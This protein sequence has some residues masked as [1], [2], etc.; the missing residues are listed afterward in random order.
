MVSTQRAEFP[1]KQWWVDNPLAIIL[2]GIAATIAVVLLFFWDRSNPWPDEWDP[3]VTDLVAYVEQDRGLTFDHPVNIR[4]VD[5][6]VI[7]EDFSGDEQTLDAYTSGDD[8][9]EELAA[10]YRALGLAE[11][12]FDFGETR[13]SLSSAAVEAYYDPNTYTIVVPVNEPLGPNDPI[14]VNTRVTLVH[15]LVHGLQHQRLPGFGPQTDN[16]EVAL[17]IMEGDA[18]LVESHYFWQLSEVEQEAYRQQILDTADEYD[19]GIATIPPVFV[20]EFADSYILGEVFV[21][22]LHDEGGFARINLSYSVPPDSM[23]AF[24]DPYS[25]L[26]AA[27]GYADDLTKPELPAGAEELSSGTAGAIQWYLALTEAMPLVDAVT[28]SRAWNGDVFVTYRSADDV[29]C[30]KSVLTGDSEEQSAVLEAALET[31][32]QRFPTSRQLESSAEGSV[33]TACD[34]GVD[35]QLNLPDDMVPLF[36]GLRYTVEGEAW[37]VENGLDAAVGACEALAELATFPDPDSPEVQGFFVF[38][39]RDVTEVSSACAPG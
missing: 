22:V 21:G 20:A 23:E 3:R 36:L 6:V 7:D 17:G 32:V 15:E 8:Q 13:D 37:A 34:P 38:P 19:E 39:D 18:S 14:P 26:E 29:V 4:F 31:W 11:G 9:T 33:V 1:K 2:L 16:I 12:E 10:I 5:P 27:E 35:A 28:A 30:V 25:W 24:V